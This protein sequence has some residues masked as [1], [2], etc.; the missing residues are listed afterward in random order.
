ML[1]KQVDGC[2]AAATRCVTQTPWLDDPGGFDCCPTE[3][4]LNYFESRQSTT[5]GA[6]MHV[7][8]SSFCYPGLK[9]YFE[10]LR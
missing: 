5:E 1:T 10:G 7:M 9:A 2:V 4:L 6:A 8:M 3:C